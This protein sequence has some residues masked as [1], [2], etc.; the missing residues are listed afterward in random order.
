MRPGALIMRLFSTLAVV[1]L[2]DLDSVL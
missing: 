2:S 1:I